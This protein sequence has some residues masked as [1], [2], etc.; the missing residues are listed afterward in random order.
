MEIYKATTDYGY[1]EKYFV[2]KQK[3]VEYCLQCLDKAFS[4]KWE[5]RDACEV[6]EVDSW[7]EAKM[8]ILDDGEM[9]CV[10]EVEVIE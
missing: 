9:A 6:Y 1:E 5:R 7:D 4:A 3:A 8:L 2:N 10:K